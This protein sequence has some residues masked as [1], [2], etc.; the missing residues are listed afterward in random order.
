MSTVGD[1]AILQLVVFEGRPGGRFGDGRL[2]KHGTRLIVILINQ[3]AALV[4][5]LYALLTEVGG[6]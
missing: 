2:D 1:S 4:V 3:C 6:Q 5:V